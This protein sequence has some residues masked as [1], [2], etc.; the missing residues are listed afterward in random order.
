MLLDTTNYYA[1]DDAVLRSPPLI[2]VVVRTTP[3]PTPPPLVTSVSKPPQL[4]PSVAHPHSQRQRKSKRRKPR[5][6]PNQGEWVLIREMDPNRPDIAQQ[7]SERALNSDSDS[8]PSPSSGEDE[9]GESES[10]DAVTASF[11]YKDAPPNLSNGHSIILQPPSFNPKATA[12]HRDSVLEEDVIRPAGLL[13]D[14]RPSLAS[15]VHTISNSVRSNT[16][17]TDVT[18]SGPSTLS[19]AS[20]QPPNHHAGGLTNGHTNG[21]NSATSPSLRQLT[22]PQAKGLST[23]TLPALQ[24]VSPAHDASSPVQQLP[25]FRHMANIAQSATTEHDV[26]RSNSFVHRPS[27]SSQSPSSVVRQLSI[28]SHSP[29]TPFPPLSASSPMSANNEN[30]TRGDLFLTTVGGSVF[31]NGNRRPSQATSENSPYPTTL[32]SASTSE[33]YQ[34]SDGPSPGSQQS[35]IEVGRP[36][37]MS[38]DS[39]LRILP[40]PPNSGLHSS[41]PSHATGSFKCEYPGCNAVPFQTQYL[42]K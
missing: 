13:P 36:R 34:S 5:T 35:P 3:S 28:S 17:G 9:M 11:A 10:P 16:N 24:A 8:D 33:S 26:G 12:T 22:I 42:L 1:D 14:R 40:P 18:P 32:H 6:R 23:D 2:A 37:L 19:A 38:M 31:G 29:A 4:T 15:S 21:I 30:Q 27:L 20:L 7:V 39:T 25:S 41:L